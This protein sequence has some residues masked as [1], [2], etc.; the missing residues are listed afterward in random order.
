MKRGRVFQKPS[1]YYGT[2]QKTVLAKS[3]DRKTA[4]KLANLGGFR[5]FV[6]DNSYDPDVSGPGCSTTNEISTNEKNKIEA[7]I[8]KAEMKGNTELVKKLREKLENL[9]KGT[10]SIASDTRILMKTNQKTG[11]ITPVTQKHL[12]SQTLEKDG[13]RNLGSV[14][15]VYHSERS[16]KEMV[17]AEKE[18]SAEDQLSMFGRAVKSADRRT[19]DDW[20]VDDMLLSA[21]K[22][23][24]QE[25][26]DERKKEAKV[27]Q[28][29]EV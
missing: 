19:D 24:K 2:S 11:L 15:S 9:L 14:E 26:R 6:S 8:L 4:A 5:D 3:V 18:M 10:A 23:K 17:M 1:D 20:V 21:K 16:V 27:I 13:K 29:A 7:K 28:G 22:R 12:Q 25:E